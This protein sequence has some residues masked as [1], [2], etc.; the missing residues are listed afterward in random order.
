MEGVK[1][2]MNGKCHKC[3]LRFKDK[4]DKYEWKEKSYCKKCFVDNGIKKICR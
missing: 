3:K 2:K 1:G 4:N